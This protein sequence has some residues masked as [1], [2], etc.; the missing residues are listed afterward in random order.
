MQTKA[1]PATFETKTSSDGDKG[2]VTAFVSVYDNVDLDGDVT[3]PGAFDADVKAAQASGD[4]IPWVFAHN[5]RSLDAY[6]GMVDPKTIETDAEF[7]DAGGEKR[8]G[9]KVEAVMPIKDDPS[10]QKAFALLKNR[11]V[12]QFSFAY[13]IVRAS[14]P[15]E[16]DAKSAEHRQTLEELKL[17]EC[18]PC[19]RGANPLTALVGAKDHDPPAKQGVMYDAAGGVAGWWIGGCMI[20]ADDDGDYSDADAAAC[21]LAIAGQLYQL[22]ELVASSPADDPDHAADVDQAAALRAAAAGVAAT[23]SDIV[24][25]D[26]SETDSGE[27]GGEASVSL[28][29]KGRKKQSAAAIAAD[30][31]RQRDLLEQEL[32]FQ[33][34]SP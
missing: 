4:P 15:S 25:T 11:V 21:A 20:E 18:G 29:G 26:V 30:E 2:I 23:A 5:S 28:N 6:I 32:A 31:L 3:A 13:D 19:L 27:A 34:L 24:A 16:K 33:A 7:T 8:R 17:F 1:V 14:K 9:L 22:A 10:A 12:K